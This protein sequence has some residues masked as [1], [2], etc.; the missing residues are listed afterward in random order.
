[1]Y[2][3]VVP[4]IVLLLFILVYSSEATLDRRKNYSGSERLD[5]VL[6]LKKAYQRAI[7]HPRKQVA[8]T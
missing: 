3:I 6:T 1:M 2:V 4:M 8:T 7:A 5:V